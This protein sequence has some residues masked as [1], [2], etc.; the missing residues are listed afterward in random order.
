MDLEESPVLASEGVASIDVLTCDLDGEVDWDLADFKGGP[1]SGS[2]ASTRGNYER[3]SEACL[4]VN[5]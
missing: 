2:R 1:N 5:K 4:V 3:L